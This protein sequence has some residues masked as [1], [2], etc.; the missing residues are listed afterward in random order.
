[1]SVTMCDHGIR[2]QI[3]VG[4]SLGG[5]AST[6]IDD[7][8]FRLRGGRAASSEAVTNICVCILPFLHSQLNTVLT[9]R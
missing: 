7:R 8:I 3:C 2:T 1:L 5:G 4:S 9:H 6:T